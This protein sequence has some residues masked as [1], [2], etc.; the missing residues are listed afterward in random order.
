MW[1]G[2]GNKKKKMHQWDDLLQ[3]RANMQ[4]VRVCA[5]ATHHP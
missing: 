1:K 2:K 5:A 3:R 4:Q